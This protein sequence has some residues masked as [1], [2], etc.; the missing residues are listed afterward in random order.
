MKDSWEEIYPNILRKQLFALPCKGARSDKFEVLNQL[1][2]ACFE[3]G[4]FYDEIGGAFRQ[5][6]SGKMRIIRGT[7]EYDPGSGRDLFTHQEQLKTCIISD[8][9]FRDEKIGSLLDHAV[10]AFLYGREK[11]GIGKPVGRQVVLDE[12]PLNGVRINN[13]YQRFCHP[14]EGLILLFKDLSFFVNKGIDRI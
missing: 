12:V 1:G 2:E 5:K 8:L 13:I 4:R 3:P 6:R 14:D 7:E 11:P 10:K 9:G